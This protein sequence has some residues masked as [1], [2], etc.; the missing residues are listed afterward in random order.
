MQ[1]PAATGRGGVK[2]KKKAG[3][4]NY[5]VGQKSACGHGEG[6]I[7]TNSANVTFFNAKPNKVFVVR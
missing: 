5:S 4:G 6:I 1:V 7:L 3:K 2:Q